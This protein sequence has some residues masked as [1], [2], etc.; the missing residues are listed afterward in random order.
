MEDSDATPRTCFSG[1]VQR[2][3]FILILSSMTEKST[4]KKRGGKGNRGK[5]EGGGADMG[6]RVRGGEEEL[7]R[8]AHFR[9]RGCLSKG[10]TQR[11]RRRGGKN[12]T[13]GVVRQRPGG[14]A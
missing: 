6:D 14:S 8:Q 12:A 3:R 2:H 4:R 13:P 5:R 7:P 9:D 10:R 1:Q 11:S